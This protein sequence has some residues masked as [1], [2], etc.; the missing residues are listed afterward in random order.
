MAME[1]KNGPWMMEVSCCK[2]LC[3]SG[4]GAPASSAGVCVSRCPTCFLQRL[5]PKNNGG[6][7]LEDA[8][9]QPLSS[10]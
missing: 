3:L 10:L 9:A 1:F 7:A 8:L 6:G 4:G 5:P 2:S